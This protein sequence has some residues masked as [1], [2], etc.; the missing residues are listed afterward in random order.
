MEGIE[1][2]STTVVAF[3][4]DPDVCLER[5]QCVIYKGPFSKDEDGPVFYR[6]KSMA[7]CRETLKALQ[8]E[9]F[10]DQFYPAEPPEAVPLLQ[11]DLFGIRLQA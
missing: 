9:P 6:G 7:V 1:F 4:R 5:N 2:R 8:R 10:A 11:L 3:K